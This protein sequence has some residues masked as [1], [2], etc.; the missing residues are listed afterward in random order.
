MLKRTYFTITITLFFN[1]ISFSQ[2]LV[3]DPTFDTGLGIESHFVLA[4]AVQADDKVVIGGGFNSFNGNTV[5]SI[6]RI[7]PDGSIDNSFNTGTGF[8]TSHVK[9]IAIQDDGKILVGGRF[10]KYNDVSIGK[11]IIRLNPDGSVDNTFDTGSGFD[12]VVETIVI[13]DDGEIFV[14]GDFANY[15]GTRVDGI[16]KIN[17]DGTLDTTFDTNPSTFQFT[18]PQ[19]Q[20]IA[21]QSNGK[22]LAGG[23]FT[24]FN[25][26][27]LSN[28]VRFNTDG[29]V[30][31]TFN[32]GAGFDDRVEVITI[33]DDGK[34][35]IGGR[36]EDFNGSFANRIIRLNANGSIDNSFDTGTGFSNFVFAIVNQDDGEILVGGNF[37]SYNGGNTPNL[38][39]LN[40]DGTNDNSFNIGTGFQ[41]TVQTI[42][43][44]ND[45]RTL[46]GG[47]FESYNGTSIGR[48]ARLMTGPLEVEKESL[49]NNVK[50]YPNPSTGVFTI[51]KPSTNEIKN[52]KV[53][54]STGREVSFSLKNISNSQLEIRLDEPSPG[55]Y[56]VKFISENGEYYSSK[57]VIE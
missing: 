48:I 41:N 1:S 2:A 5:G 55:I 15:K 30:D 17:Q 38:V 52:I 51:N 25:N 57:L 42:I 34:L 40:T 19:I 49:I 33:Q 29:S 18:T 11:K 28:V 4:T 26:I 54:E 43:I 6:V 10:D 37:S 45:K 35:L 27:T 56:F 53:F 14:G 16:A 23:K 9:A 47:W 21:I 7:N 44:L 32:T 50:M 3:L 24:K 20:A 22:I 13:L 8:K 12:E 36:F 46:I 31:N 39:R